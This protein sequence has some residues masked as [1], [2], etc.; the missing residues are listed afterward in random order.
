MNKVALRRT[1]KWRQTA[2][3]RQLSLESRAHKW[4]VKI[5]ALFLTAAASI[6]TIE[7]DALNQ[8]A[9]RSASRAPPFKQQFLCLPSRRTSNLPANG[10]RELN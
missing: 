5:A 1:W 7:T 6:R 3:V 2:L 8:L 10:A 9:R 4:R